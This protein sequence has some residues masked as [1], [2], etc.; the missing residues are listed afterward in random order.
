[1]NNPP[2]NLKTVKEILDWY[3]ST[4]KVGD[5]VPGK[6]VRYTLVNGLNQAVQMLQ[7]VKQ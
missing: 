6:I 3:L 5:I 4:Y 1:M 2:D 7:A